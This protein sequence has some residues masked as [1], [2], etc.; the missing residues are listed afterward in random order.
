MSVLSGSMSFKA[1][2]LES[3]TTL[4]FEQN[5]WLEKL[6]KGIFKG[7]DKDKNQKEAYGFTDSMDVFATNL[8][9][10]N[11]FIENYVYFNF[12]RDVIKLQKKM[13]NVFI[14]EVENKYKGDNLTKNRM[15]DIKI[16]AENLYAQKVLPNVY[17]YEVVWNYEAGILYFFN[18]SKSINEKFVDFFEKITDLS[19][20]EIETSTI[21]YKLLNEKQFQQFEKLPPSTLVTFE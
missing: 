5:E 16:E 19:L 10:N 6:S 13:L 14:K 17:S 21:A 1:Y 7:I 20:I 9:I 8:N 4:N 2:Y 18:N 15:K 3:H 11:L 12:R